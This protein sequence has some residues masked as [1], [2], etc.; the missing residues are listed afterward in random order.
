[1]IFLSS[2]FHFNWGDRDKRLTNRKNINY[3]KV[4]QREKAEK[5]AITYD[6]EMTWTIRNG[7]Q[8]KPY[9][10]KGF[11]VKIWRHLGELSLCCLGRSHTG[12]A[13]QAES[14]GERTARHTWGI[15][16]RLVCLQ[17]SEQEKEEGEQWFYRSR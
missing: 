12:R 15:P 4:L 16:W 13:Q 17:Q 6:V 5:I 11:W 10:E 8:G 9:K 3:G 14:R 1:M 7:G 2:D